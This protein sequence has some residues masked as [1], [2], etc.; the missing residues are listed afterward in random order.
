[1]RGVKAGEKEIVQAWFEQ[2]YFFLFEF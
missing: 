2:L 1:L